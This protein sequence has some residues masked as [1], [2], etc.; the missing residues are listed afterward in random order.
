MHPTNIMT[1]YDREKLGTGLKTLEV[2]WS[3]GVTPSQIKPHWLFSWY[4][5]LNCNFRQMAKVTGFSP[6]TLMY[7]HN[8]KLGLYKLLPLR[9]LWLGIV[10]NEIYKHLKH[11]KITIGN[12][13]SFKLDLNEHKVFINALQ[14]YWIKNFFIERHHGLFHEF[15]KKT[16]FEP[17]LNQRENKDLIGLW[18]TGF[19][20]KML[21]PSFI[22][23]AL[24]NNKDSAYILDKIG[25]KYKNYLHHHFRKWRL[26]QSMTHYWLG[27]LVPKPEDWR[28]K[29]KKGQ[30]KRNKLGRFC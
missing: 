5:L 7:Y 15:W 13:F 8:K 24:R 30:G 16:N 20:N 10:N 25:Y 9:K 23:W 22:L 2:L 1:V 17:R 6:Y 19:P 4:T 18:R 28:L 29:G 26:K 21:A 3:R 12:K 11:S 14:K 27:P